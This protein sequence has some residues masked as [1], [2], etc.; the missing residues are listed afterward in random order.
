MRVTL[1]ALRFSIARS[2]K[3]AVHLHIVTQC[4]IRK[5]TNVNWALLLV[6]IQILM[7]DMTHQL[8]LHM[9]L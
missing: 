2:L 3:I 6:N 9:L 5:I 1:Y 7:H 4:K 8:Y